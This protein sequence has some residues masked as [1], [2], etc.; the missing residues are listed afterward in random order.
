MPLA[1]IHT[2]PKKIELDIIA[3]AADATMQKGGSVFNSIISARGEQLKNVLMRRGL[4]KAGQARRMKCKDLVNDYTRNRNYQKLVVT[5]APEWKVGFADEIDT[6]KQC[7]KNILNTVSV[8]GGENIGIGLIDE[9]GYGIPD[10]IALDTAVQTI[11][12][13]P[14]TARVNIFLI[15]YNYK[16]PSIEYKPEIID[17]LVCYFAGSHKEIGTSTAIGA[18]PTCG[19]PTEE[20]DPEKEKDKRIISDLK[21]LMPSSG[22]HSKMSI[23]VEG[24]ELDITD[25]MGESFSQMLLRKIDESGMKDSEVYK[26][27][28]VSKQLFSKIRS[29]I[30]YQPKKGTVI[31]FA[32][33]LQLDLDGTKELLR[34]AGFLLTN[35][36]V[37]DRIIIVCINHNIH[38][39]FKVNEY[40]YECNQPLLGS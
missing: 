33:A 4:E 8:L 23:C 37:S 19:V 22:S 17:N 3:V 10:D 38:S 29:N 30:H 12:E 14:V 11:S 18:L 21:E 6:L 27:A 20:L 9:K 34:T 28:Q 13:H 39:L 16:L 36:R 1:L 40:L 32:L 24:T 7:Y 5:V 35:S 31:A 2:N 25:G 15:T 26:K